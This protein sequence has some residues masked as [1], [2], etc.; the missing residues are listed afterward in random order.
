MRTLQSLKPKHAGRGAVDRAGCL[1]HGVR[2]P[3]CGPGWLASGG[4]HVRSPRCSPL[5]MCCCCGTGLCGWP[6]PQ[7]SRP[8]FLPIVFLVVPSPPPS[9]SQMLSWCPSEG[10]LHTLNFQTEYSTLPSSNSFFFSL[11]FYKYLLCAK[12]LQLCLTLCNPID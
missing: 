4:R 12:S 9:P 3:C 1:V 7:P 5:K 2:C 11:P 10:Q 6:Q 8:A